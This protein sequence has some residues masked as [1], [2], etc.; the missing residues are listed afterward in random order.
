MLIQ[1]NLASF[2]KTGLPTDDLE[3]VEYEIRRMERSINS[4]L[5]YARPEKCEF[6]EFAIQEVLQRTAQL[7]SGRCD[8]QHVQLSI[9]APSKPV[10]LMG[11]PA[12]IQQ[13]LLNLA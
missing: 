10:R 9:Q 5:E 2:A 4:L 6:I 8:L 12:Q 11:D 7:I 1:V 13:L 3:L